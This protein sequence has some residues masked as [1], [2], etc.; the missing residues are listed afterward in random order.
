VSARA[1]SRGRGLSVGEVIVALEQGVPL[2]D[3]LADG[4]GDPSLEVAYRLTGSPRWVD[5]HGR[6]VPEPSPAPGR[7]QTTIERA[8]LPIAVIDYDAHVAADPELIDAVAAA[9]GLSI[10]NERLSAGLR[11]Q[12]AFLETVTDTAP[13]LL[14]NVSSEGRILNQ[15]RAAVAVAGAADQD[16]IHGRYFWDVFIDENERADVIARF[17]ASAPE[18]SPGEYV[19]R[20]TNHRGERRVIYWRSAPVLGEDGSVLSIIAG[21]LDITEREQLAEEKE[22][23][24][25]FL[26]AIAN[27]APSLLCL[28]DEEGR[29]ADRA[30]NLAF[31]RT[32]EYAPEETGGHVFWERY[33]DPAEADE[34]R[35]LVQRVVAGEPVG[36]HDH[37]WLTSSGQRLLIAWTCTPLP[38]LDERTLFLISGVD[39]TER[40]EREQEAERRRDFLNAITIAVPSFLIAVDPSGVFVEDA[41]NLAFRDAFGWTE[42]ELRGQSFV[43]LIVRDDQA[44]VGTIANA[45]EVAQEEQESRWFARSGEA[46]LVAWTARPVLDPEGRKLVLVSG[47]D[48]TL[49]RRQEE[50]IRAS[51]ARIVRAGDEAR[52]ALERD[53]HDGAQQRLVALSVALRLVESKLREKPDEA[54]HLLGGAREELARALEELRELARGIHP[55]VLTDRGLGPA[56]EALAARAPIPVELEAPTERLAPAVEAAAYYVVA[57]SLT[58]M[59]KYG[60]ATSAQVSLATEN[61]TLQVTVSDDGVGGADPERGSG[62]RGLADRVEALEGRFVVTSPPGRGTTI[63]AEIPLHPA[64]PTPG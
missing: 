6:A 7:A 46:R 59:A 37:H 13:S 15:N 52:R 61:G 16:E 33:V 11:A 27:N 2:R 1:D 32:L 57:E 44:V 63:A 62:L 48:V 53:L 43:D 58:N 39:V 3:A 23:E 28:I 35:R 60:Q 22:R 41:S 54:V 5:V 30:T 25:E 56:L 9:A 36:E 40:M 17:R 19:N 18:Y 26:N 38:R 21:G 12:Y 8:G 55:A 4:L 24:R 47:S 51:R 45:A 14:V 42:Q 50:E 31:E 20:F 49:R 29:L 34:V 10:Q 64:R